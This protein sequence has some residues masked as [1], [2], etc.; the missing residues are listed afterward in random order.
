VAINSYMK[1][2]DIDA[3]F[4][5]VVVTCGDTGAKPVNIFR[6]SWSFY[7]MSGDRQNRANLPSTK[8]VSDFGGAL[9]VD[10]SGSPG[11]FTAKQVLK[12]G[13]LKGTKIEFTLAHSNLGNFSGCSFGIRLPCASDNQ[14]VWFCNNDK[15]R[16]SEPVNKPYSFTWVADRDWPA[17]SELI[18]HG[19]V[20][21]GQA[22]YWFIGAE[23][24]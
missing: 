21:P 7:E 3:R 19:A 4:S 17:G 1:Y 22:T 10:I 20:W 14:I 23:T 16:S 5:N 2:Y 11:A 13:C 24:K 6:D 15:T 9:R 8:S 18:W 12:D